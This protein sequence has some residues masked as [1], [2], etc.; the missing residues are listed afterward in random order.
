[1]FVLPFLIWRP[2]FMPMKMEAN[3]QV[4]SSAHSLLMFPVFCLLT[5][6][7]TRPPTMFHVHLKPICQKWNS[8]ILPFPS[9]SCLTLWLPRVIQWYCLSMEPKHENL[10]KCLP[11]PHLP[12]WSAVNTS[13]HTSHRFFLSSRP[14]CPHRSH[15]F[16]VSLL[17]LTLPSLPATIS[18][19][20][21]TN[22]MWSC[23]FLRGFMA[24][25]YLPEKVQTEALRT[26]ELLLSLSLRSCLSLTPPHTVSASPATYSCA[27]ASPPPPSPVPSALWMC[28]SH[29]M[30]LSLPSQ[31][32]FLPGSYSP[33][34]TSLLGECF[35]SLPSP[36]RLV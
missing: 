35:H 8:M 5:W 1:M 24:T 33:F 30:C 11:F 15:S 22:P 28:C 20:F 18:H 14:Y 2:V 27:R 16:V 12:S 9:S 13:A 32:P 34:K 36:P 21:P 7:S 25:I 10:P 26:S 3:W 6:H 19:S 4:S 29:C 31:H 23:P 17:C